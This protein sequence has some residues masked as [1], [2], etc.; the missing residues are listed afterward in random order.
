MGSLCPITLCTLMCTQYGDMAYSTNKLSVKRIRSLQEGAHGDGGGLWLRKSANGK[1]S[2]IYRYR[3]YGKQR[4]MGLGS[5]PTV[6]L[7]KARKDRDQWAEIVE[8]GLDPQL[9]RDRASNDIKAQMVTLDDVAASAFEARKAELKEDG[10]AG[11]WFSPLKLHVLPKIGSLPATHI[12]QTHIKDAVGPI[13][14]EKADTARKALNRLNICLRHAVA[15]GLDVDVSA[16]E[17][18]KVLLGRQNHKL[19]NIPAMPWGD[20]PEF[21]ASLTELTPGHLALK[22]L[23]LNPGPRSK[24]VRFLNEAQLDGDVW[25]VPSDLMKGLKGRGGDWRTPLALQSLE[26]IRSARLFA[27]QDNLFPNVSGRGVISD[28]TMS[29]LMERRGL[30][31]RPHGFRASFRTWA[32]ETGQ[33]RDISEL[34]L[35]HKIHGDVEAAYLRTDFLEERRKTLN[36]W[37]DHVTGKVD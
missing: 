4:Q 9:E 23:I 28:A 27:R 17:K 12:T 16:V 15:M 14:H 8:R 37:A 3:L 32:A 18:A 36:A 1:A 29:R 34:C 10:R 2:W 19:E 26:I 24:P 22:F 33:P 21:F 25:T 31:Y 20:V 35:A 6:S 30:V 5:Y 11:R 13:W 7:A